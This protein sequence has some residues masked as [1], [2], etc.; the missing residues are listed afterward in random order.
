MPRYD[1]S[2]STSQDLTFLDIAEGADTQASQ[3]DYT[4]FTA[5]SQAATQ[6]SQTKGPSSRRLHDLE[7]DVDALGLPSLSLS[8]QPSQHHLHIPN[9][10][11]TSASASN[12]GGKAHSSSRMTEDVY[13]SN[14]NGAELAFEETDA[15][16]DAGDFEAQDLPEHACKYCGIHSPSSVVKC[17]ACAKWFCNSRG[18][19]SG[20]HIVNHLVRAR[21]KEVSLH[22]ESPLGE[23]ILE[24]YNC[25]SRNTFLLGFIP[26]KSDT[27]VVLLCRQP[28]ASAPSSKDMTWDLSQWLPLI[29]DK[30]F[31]PWLVKV[32]TDQEQMRARQITNA[33]IAKLEEI[34]KDNGSATIEDLERPGADDEPLPVQLR[35]DDAYQY[36]NIFGPLVKLEA[37][38]DRRLKESQTQE[39]V[40]VRW[41]MGLNMK[42]VA[43]FVL[44]KLEQGEIRLAVGDEI[45][46]RYRGELHAPWEDRGPVIK[47]PNNLSDEVAIE[48]RKA[49]NAPI[50][51]TH[52]FTVDF[53]WK[54]TSFDRM[55]HAMKRFALDQNSVSA[56]IYHRLLGHDV[57]PQ[58]LHVQMPKRVSAPSL[59]ELNHS[60]VFAV[61]S[62]LTKPLSLIQGP[63]GTGKTVTSATIVYHLAKMND[64][65]ILVCAPSN[66]AVDQLTE[67]IHRTGLKV[68]RVAAKSREALDSS[69]DA[70]TLHEQV[71]NNDS[72]P[73]LQKL[74]RLRDELG[75]LSAADEKRYRMLGR[76]AERDILSMADVICT[77]CTGAGDPRLAKLTFRTTLIDESTQAAEPECLIPLVLGARQAVLVGDHQQLGPVIISKR[78]AK[79]GLSQS[80]FERLVLLGVRPIRLQVQYRMHPCLSEFPSNMFYEGSLQNGV[81]A[82]ERIRPS[83]DFP[84]PVLETPM[85]F[86]CSFGQ[87][88][89]SSSG[90]SYLNRTEAANVEKVV[91]RLLKAGITPIHIGVITPYEGQR[92]YVVQHMQFAGSLRRELYKEIEVASVDAFQGREK[93]Y[94]VVSCVRSN[95]HQGI[96]FLNDPRRLN[97]AL[98]R[99]KY[100]VVILGNP[101][102]LSRHPLWYQLLAM[103][104][105]KGCLVE[106]PLS[107]L[108]ISQIQLMKPRIRKDFGAGGEYGL[109]AS[110]ARRFVVDAREHFAKAPNAQ[111][112]P[113]GAPPAQQPLSQQQQQQ[114]YNPFDNPMGYIDPSRVISQSQTFLPPPP[115]IPFSQASL[116]GGGD[117]PPLVAQ[118]NNMKSQNNS[119]PFSQLPFTQSQQSFSQ[120]DRI[121]ANHNV[122]VGKGSNGYSH[123]SNSKQR[124]N[125]D[126]YLLEDYKSQN[127]D[128]WI[129]SHGAAV[130]I[131]LMKMERAEFNE[132]KLQV[133]TWLVLETVAN[134]TIEQAV[135]IGDICLFCRS[136]PTNECQGRTCKPKD[137]VCINSNRHREVIKKAVVVAKYCQT[138]RLL[139]PSHEPSVRVTNLDHVLSRYSTV[140][141]HPYPITL[142]IQQ[143]RYNAL[144]RLDVT[145]LFG[146]PSP[147]MDEYAPGTAFARW[148]VTGWMVHTRAFTP[149][150]KR[151][152]V[153]GDCIYKRFSTIWDNKSDAQMRILKRIGFALRHWCIY[154]GTTC[155]FCAL[156]LTRS[157]KPWLPPDSQDLLVCPNCLHPTIPNLVL[158]RLNEWTNFPDYIEPDPSRR[159]CVRLATLDSFLVNDQY[160]YLD[161]KYPVK[162]PNSP[163]TDSEFDW[164]RISKRSK[165]KKVLRWRRN[166]LPVAP[167]YTLERGL[168]EVYALKYPKDQHY[169]LLRNSCEHFVRWCQMGSFPHSGFF[170]H[171]TSKVLAIGAGLLASAASMILFRHELT[172]PYQYLDYV[173]PVPNLMIPTVTILSSLIVGISVNMLARWYLSQSGELPIP[174]PTPYNVSAKKKILD[175]PQLL[176][177]YFDDWGL[178]QQL[179]AHPHWRTFEDVNTH[180]T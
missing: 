99:A 11:G 22:P 51:L 125:P 80:L 154:V 74:S 159:Y 47:I 121:S 43:Y 166:S 71:R 119:L 8:S 152:L 100:G 87:E 128:E 54:S 160:I 52:G 48:L 162:K 69:V 12:V 88:E 110:T 41:D 173:L 145:R 151:V 85:M 142:S 114:R 18:K 176:E 172:S 107:N 70:L 19:I 175:S 44:P 156:M 61:K 167:Y 115:M 49:D 58:A 134:R 170:P 3:Y 116:P 67:K 174:H 147:W 111:D 148:C 16:G 86:H 37:D 42:R 72:M 161:N 29:D 64:G 23:T 130:S 149:L 73:E 117:F 33:Q 155:V 126:D 104:K 65:Q 5:P 132:S 92:S 164:D 2:S 38:T 133:G 179:H 102:V 77:T 1:H 140:Q 135:Y 180:S 108:K 13:D 84:W 106:G 101:K 177:R 15:D 24:C 50:D 75:E 89:I 56:Y 27:V 83:I 45:V 141:I 81:T 144:S 55:Q 26:A 9:S 79:A 143:I 157:C 82:Q 66:V 103:Y 120:Y 95:E 20:S 169:Q 124:R 78:A 90:T 146:L 123:I 6:K 105:E 96:G 136:A 28:C 93:D 178:N 165:L 68:V 98:T 168:G 10:S 7:D 139:S 34:W 21:H 46:L 62:V 17:I 109:S 150:K 4:D 91:T 35:Y 25:G 118:S 94:I 63:P 171:K 30:C 60:Q 53:V 138:T 32:P 158:D 112:F 153:P 131:T 76:A 39:D 36:Q 113:R 40:I 97:V 129:L 57:E 14:L 59:P 163:N 137:L 31:L 127:A 122:D